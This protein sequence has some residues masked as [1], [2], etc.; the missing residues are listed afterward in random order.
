MN[1]AGDNPLWTFQPDAS[2]CEP[3]SSFPSEARAIQVDDSTRILVAG[4]C[5]SPDDPDGGSTMVVMRL[6][7]S[8]NL[9]TEFGNGTGAVFVKDFLHGGFEI[10]VAAMVF[11]GQGRLVVTGHTFDA[12]GNKDMIV[13]RLKP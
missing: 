3:G 4:V 12:S 1:T 7:S 9:D 8:G 10:E 13:V 6:T 2:L 11:D 5:K